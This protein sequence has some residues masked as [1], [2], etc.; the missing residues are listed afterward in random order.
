MNCCCSFLKE[1]LFI[2]KQHLQ[3]LVVLDACLRN[4]YGKKTFPI[5]YEKWQGVTLVITHYVHTKSLLLLFQFF[6]G[7]PSN[8]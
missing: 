6:S 7:T 8:V 5:F 1:I 2:N 4:R 3:N